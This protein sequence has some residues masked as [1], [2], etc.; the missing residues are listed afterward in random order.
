MAEE[1]KYLGQVVDHFKLVELLGEGEMSEV[2]KG[3]QGDLITAIKIP[4]G[5]EFIP[6]IQKG[7]ETLT[8]LD[9]PNIIKLENYGTDH[10]TGI[11]FL[12]TEYVKGENL[13]KLISR[14][15]KLDVKNAVDIV[16]QVLDAIEYSHNK[17]V[18]HGDIH[19][20]NI[21]VDDT[22][23]VKVTDF[24]LAMMIIKSEGIYPHKKTQKTSKS[25][26][27]ARLRKKEGDMLTGHRDYLSPEERKGTESTK[28]S[29]IYKISKVLFKMLTGDLKEEGDKLSDFI[30]EGY[31]ELDNIIG[32]G[33][34]RPPENRFSSA[35]EMYQALERFGSKKVIVI[36]PEVGKPSVD[37]IP[38]KEFETK[39]NGLVSLL[40]NVPSDSLTH[41]I[42]P[43]KIDEIN[44]GYQKLTEYAKDKGLYDEDNVKRRL[45]EIHGKIMEEKSTDRKTIISTLFPYGLDNKDMKKNAENLRDK[46]PFGKDDKKGRETCKQVCMAW[47]KVDEDF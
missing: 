26:V 6:Y 32:K 23:N 21:L 1:G 7:A 44:T 14:V 47:N 17:E 29:D 34:T 24:G 9:H 16:L 42:P 13:D 28:K 12:R 30:G 38:I 20:G 31:E 11:Y 37:N 35:K 3:Q 36:T 15:T 18:I 2:Y 41:L 40:D 8:L 27:Y 43:E 46:K 39:Y 33:I 45:E 25:G 22:G 10:E 19:P 4:K 5:K